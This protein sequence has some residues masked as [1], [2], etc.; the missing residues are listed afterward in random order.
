MT[1]KKCDRPRRLATTIKVRVCEANG[2][3]RMESNP[4]SPG[5]TLKM[6]ENPKSDDVPSLFGASGSAAKGAKSREAASEQTMSMLAALGAS[7][8]PLVGKA[9]RPVSWPN[10]VGLMLLLG[11]IAFAAYIYKTMR[12]AAGHAAIVAGAVLPA[13][14]SKPLPAAS[15]RAPAPAP[16]PVPA[17]T[18]QLETVPQRHTPAVAN[19]LERTTSQF[20]NAPIAAA[21]PPATAPRVVHL[22]A[23]PVN[24]AAATAAPARA[25]PPAAALA[26]APKAA[27]GDADVELLAALMA[28]PN[29]T[30]PVTASKAQQAGVAPE[31]AKQ[32]DDSNIATLVQRC[33]SRPSKQESLACRRRI[34]QGYWGKAEACPKALAPA[35]TTTRKAT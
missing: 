3:P 11:G 28:H 6:P 5:P 10:I 25:R 8:S 22:E 14:A 16:A 27:V 17:P 33:A 31:P 23:K 19:S 9:R 2:N 29:L 15:L 24:R 26:A 1:W 12:D 34:C 4:A 7:R 32:R 20:A 13:A 35:A 18:A 30:G 21:V